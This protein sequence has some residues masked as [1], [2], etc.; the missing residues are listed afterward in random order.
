MFTQI[1]GF[2]R[3]FV[4][5]LEARTGQTDDSHRDGRTDRHV[6]RP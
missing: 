6:L 4:S 2:V 5:E 3:H 1:W